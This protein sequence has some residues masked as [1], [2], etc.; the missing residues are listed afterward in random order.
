MSIDCYQGQDLPV[1]SLRLPATPVYRKKLASFFLLILLL[2]GCANYGTPKNV[3][4]SDPREADKY[5]L[6]DWEEGHSNSDL[7]LTLTF[8]GGGT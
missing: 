6:H 2:S 3:E 5:S 4:I 1:K 7:S 8:S